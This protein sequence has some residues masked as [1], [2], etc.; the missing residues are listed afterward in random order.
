MT[1]RQAWQFLACQF[2]NL[3]DGVPT[4]D[5]TRSGMCWGIKQLCREGH[6]SWWMRRSML[7]ELNRIRVLGEFWYEVGEE[8]AWNRAEICLNFSE[9]R[10]L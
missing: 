3:A 10:L 1:R 8:G 7:A 9:R 6:I 5:Y 4:N 2:I